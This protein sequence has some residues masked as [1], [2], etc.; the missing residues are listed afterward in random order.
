MRTSFLIDGFNLYHSIK[1]AE[2]FNNTKLRWLDLYSLCESYLPN[3]DT[4]AKIE[5]IHYFSAH[6]TH[7]VSKDK[8]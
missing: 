4:K 2:K 5:S 8:M 1:D 3:I 6:A 7:R